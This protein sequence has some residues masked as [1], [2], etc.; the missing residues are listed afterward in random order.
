MRCANISWAGR[1]SAKLCAKPGGWLEA[2][3]GGAL[4]ARPMARIF[5]LGALCAGLWLA[6]LA[7][8]AAP[9]R[10]QGSD[11]PYW[12]TI[13]F[14]KVYM[15][16]GPGVNY[17]IDWVYTREGLPVKVIRKREG[18]RLVV[19]PDGAQGWI[20]SSQLK[21][22]RSVIV[23]GQGLAIMRQGPEAGSAV[24]F[25]AEPGVVGRLVR[26]SAAWCEID[27]AGR[28]GWVEAARLWGDEEPGAPPAR[29][30]D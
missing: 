6:G 17:P 30:V 24:R 14:D 21:R 20:A 13:R 1:S 28:T 23:Q 26:C 19:D 9:V 11:P 22:E 5:A 3:G 18:W 2:A 7:L 4:S 27:V 8:L 25:R 15:R 29:S 12:A 16:V 10:A